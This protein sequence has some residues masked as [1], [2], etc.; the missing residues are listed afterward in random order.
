MKFKMKAFVYLALITTLPFLCIAEYD[1]AA[2]AQLLRNGAVA[3]YV[4]RVVDDEGIPVS[5]ATAHIWF[6]SYGR[7]QDEAGWVAETDTNGIFVAEHRLNEKFSVGIDKEG[8][9]HTHDEIN[10]FGMSAEMRL[11]IVKDGKWQPY[12]E[13]RTVVLKKIRNPIQIGELG[14]CSVPVPAY[15]KWVGF[16]LEQRKWTPPYGDGKYSDVLLKFGREL[17]H[18][19]FDYKMT[20]EVSFTNNPYA[21][22][23]QLKDD[24]FSER[25][26]VYNADPH[27]EFSASISYIQ[28]R[29]PNSPRND[30]RLDDDSYLIFR[31]RTKTD[32]DGKLISAHYGIICGR[33]SFFSSMLSRGYLFNP[34]PNDTNLEDAE[35]ARLSRL[36]YKQRLEFERRRKAGGK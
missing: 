8:Y 18:G 16:D 30:N 23:Y 32:D 33:W 21:G 4:Y 2:F 35:T 6:K 27:M 34:T 7:P 3:K 25:K 22:F 14:R 19:Q 36:G 10:Y 12:G 1:E 28:E 31:T 26:T 29:H 17:V 11:S 9:Y 24:G 15:D 5:N 20:M 13:E